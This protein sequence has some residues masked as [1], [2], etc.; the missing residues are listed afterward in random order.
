[1]NPN[2]RLSAIPLDDQ[3]AFDVL[4]NGHF[5]GIFQFA[6]RALRGLC[7][8]MKVTCL[9]DMVSI[10]SLARPGPMDSGAA[11]QWV[12]RKTGREEI[13]YRHPLFQPILETTLGIVVYQEQVMRIGREIG[14]LSWEDVNALRRAMGKSQGA[15][16]FDAFGSKW[17]PAAIAKG[18]ESEIADKAWSELCT[19]GRYG[20]NRSHAV[21]YSIV[22]YWACWLKAHHP[23]EFAAATLDAESDPQK[24]IALLRELKSEGIDYVAVD[25]DHSTDKW[26]PITTDRGQRLVGPL[27]SIRGIGPATVLEILDAR[28]SGKPIRETLRKRLEQAT[29]GL[30]TLYPITD[31]V[32][33]L[34]P[35]LTSINIVSRPT[36][37]AKVQ[38]GINGEV[39][40]IGVVKK[41][42]PKDE[43]QQVSVAKREA[44]GRRGLLNGPI[45][46]LNLFIQDDTDEIFAKIDRYR[47][48]H[49]GIPIVDRGRAGKSLWALKG[50]CPSGFR[51]LSVTAVK[52]LGDMEDD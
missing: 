20:F 48:P 9:E 41:I 36:P 32:Q 26:E 50:S 49:L 33:K 47:Y 39:M 18:I 43:N 3:A 1:M 24:Q 23:L 5:A 51:M 45:Q 10:T 12:R 6:G 37:I 40:I 16:T 22:S 42:A 38:C 29:T 17:K 52:Y 14:D 46:A 15:E 28:K 34:H 27:T 31:R 44:A 4:N 19:F 30:D 13:V 21:A 2:D 7:Q 11:E 8:K 25:P 35:D